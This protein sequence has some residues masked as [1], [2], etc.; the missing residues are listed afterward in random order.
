[1]MCRALMVIPPALKS[2]GI[3]AR[4]VLSSELNI[5]SNF[6]IPGVQKCKSNPIEIVQQS[7]DVC[8]F[9]ALIAKHANLVPVDCGLGS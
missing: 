2:Y 6:P 3:Q 5:T 9:I 7:V 8:S 1:M 4:I